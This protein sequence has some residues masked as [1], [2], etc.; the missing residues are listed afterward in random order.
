VITA[1]YQLPFG[2]SRQ[3]MNHEPGWVDAILGGWETDSIIT[4]MSGRAWTPVVGYD[5]SNSGLGSYGAAERAEIVGDP[6]PPG[7]H[8]GPL[9]LVDPS[10]FPDPETYSGTFGN[11]GRNSLRGMDT[12]QWDLSFMKNFHIGERMNLELKGSFFN[13]T[14]R[15]GNGAAPDNYVTDG[16]PYFGAIV[17]D[18]ADIWAAA[19]KQLSV[20]FTF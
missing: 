8:P 12:R 5:N 7:F 9:G 17:Y 10:V 13:V 6:T 16:S 1:M 20:R 14:H 2:R 18:K 11:A 15:Y 3:W 19:D 4:Y